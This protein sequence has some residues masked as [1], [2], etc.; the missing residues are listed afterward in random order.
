MSKDKLECIRKVNKF[1]GYEPLSEEQLAAVDEPTKFEVM[2]ATKGP[3][4]GDNVYVKGKVGQSQEM[5]SELQR[6]AVVRQT[7]RKL[8][9]LEEQLPGCYFSG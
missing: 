7:E 8:A 6:A 5:L 1:L 3:V 9:G 4:S 2:C